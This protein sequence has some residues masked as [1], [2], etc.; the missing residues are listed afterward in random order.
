LWEYK[1]SPNSYKKHLLELSDIVT[2]FIEQI[3]SKNVGLYL[4]YKP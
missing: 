4:N 2:F 3:D 1:V